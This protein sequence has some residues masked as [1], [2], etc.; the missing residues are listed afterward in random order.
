M[1]NLIINKEM[2]K[3]RFIAIT[4]VLVLNV[5][6]LQAQQISMPLDTNKFCFF[7]MHKSCAG[8]IV[9]YEHLQLNNL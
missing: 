2:K 6:V 3:F 1:L 9:S 4:A 5:C 7:P 8:K